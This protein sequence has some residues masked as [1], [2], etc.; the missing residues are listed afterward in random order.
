M[1]LLKKLYGKLV[2]KVNNIDTS[3]F[4][5]R[6]KYDT[7]K[8]HLEKKISDSDKKNSW[9]TQHATSRGRPPVIQEPP[10]DQHKNWWFNEKSVF[11]DAIV[12]VLHIYWCFLL[13]K[14]IFK[15]SKW[16]RSRNVYGTQTSRQPNGA[17]FWGCPRDVSH[18]CFL[19][20]GQK[21][22]KLTLT[23]YLRFYNEL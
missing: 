21:H 13:E 9:L 8:S 20:S 14:Q 15:I 6:T 11:L 19:N 1:K 22:F 18:A 5:L 3:G 2:A 12:L 17:T 10:G 7:D 23:G 4:V 16:E